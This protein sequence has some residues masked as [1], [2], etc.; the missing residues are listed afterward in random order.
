MKL[1]Q[2]WNINLAML[3]RKQKGINSGKIGKIDPRASAI[4][5]V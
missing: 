2:T 5:K 1:V 3:I 4:L